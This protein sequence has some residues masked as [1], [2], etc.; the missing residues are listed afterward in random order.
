MKADLM[1]TYIY[2]YTGV[3]IHDMCMHICGK[4]EHTCSYAYMCLD[5]IS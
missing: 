5:V 3:S 4:H 2:M 1:Y